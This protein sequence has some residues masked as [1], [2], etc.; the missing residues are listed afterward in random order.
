MP[1]HARP[2]AGL[3]IGTLAIGL[4]IGQAG[5]SGS[6]SDDGTVRKVTFVIPNSQLNF[7]TEMADGFRSGVSQVGGVEEDVVGPPV[8]DGPKQLKI[9]Q[10]SMKDSKDG[11]SVFTMN[12]ELLAGPMADA[13]RAGIPLIA[14]DNPPPPSSNVKLFI[15]N[16]NYLLGKTLADEAI[17]KLPPNA[18]GTVVIGT[19][20]P[21]VPVL[22]RRAAG[23]RDRFRER[24]PKVSVL[25]PFDSK[26]EVAANLNAWRTLVRANPDALAFLGTG[27]ADGWNLAAIRKSTKGKWVAGAFDLDP[28]SMQAVKEGNLVLVSPEHFVKGAIAGRLQAKH[29]KDRTALPEGWIYTPGLAVNSGTTDAIIARQASPAAKAAAQAAQVDKILNDPSYVHPLKDV[30]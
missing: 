19:S 14:V 1:R 12:P 8:V 23:I 10:N 13:A 11:I 9:F 7:A 6:A 15:G 28:K 22:D 3:L 2:A 16:D 17:A 18:T 24:L 21:G 26:Q 20:S 27:D 4:I 29:A 25:G 5:C 30:S